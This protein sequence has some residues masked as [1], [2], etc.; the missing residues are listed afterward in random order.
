M[1]KEIKAYLDTVK[2]FLAENHTADET[3]KFR[4]DLL[5]RIRFYQ[6]E[7]L[8]H[9]LVMLAFAFF[10]L[11]SLSL[12]LLKGGAALAVLTLLFLALLIPYIKHYYFL[13]NSVQRLYKYYYVLNGE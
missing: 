2:R 7:R 10:F 3:E 1:T 13:E 9:L 4:A 8:V 5:E 6:H 11:I 12:M